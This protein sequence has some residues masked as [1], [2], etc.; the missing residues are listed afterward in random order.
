MAINNN[1][2]AIIPCLECGSELEFHIKNNVVIGGNGIIAGNI[3]A[4]I[5]P[6]C[7]GTLLG[8][9]PDPPGIIRLDGLSSEMARVLLESF[10]FILS[11]SEAFKFFRGLFPEIG[12]E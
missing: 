1:R 8:K 3:P 7:I 5:C 12:R 11:R 4:A 9:L 2:I 6:D 10:T